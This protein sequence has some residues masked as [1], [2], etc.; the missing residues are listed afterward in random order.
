MPGLE[1]RPLLP[2]SGEGH[3]GPGIWPQSHRVPVD[4]NNGAIVILSTSISSQTDPDVRGM[5]DINKPTQGH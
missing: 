4:R 1:F 5:R 3:M 2:D